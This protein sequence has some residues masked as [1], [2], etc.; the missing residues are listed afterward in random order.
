MEQLVGKPPSID[1][2]LAKQNGW[3]LSLDRKENYVV[4]AAINLWEKFVRTKGMTG[5][6]YY[7]A[8]F[9]RKF[10][11]NEHGIQVE[12]VVGWV[13][14]KGSKSATSHA[15]IEY[16]GKITDIS[17]GSTEGVF[18]TLPAEIIIH[19]FDYCPG[20]GTY[21]YYRK[22]PKRFLDIRYAATVD[23]ETSLNNRENDRLNTFFK[24]L[25]IN[26]EQEEDY[27]SVIPVEYQYELL[28]ALLK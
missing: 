17:L 28:A 7:L 3:L 19:G 20:I 13:V 14:Q 25:S 21:G 26:P 18:C 1:V 5:G 4:Q 8:L 16:Q 27:F 15:W 11:K 24:D 12:V 2:K 22:L 23:L 9:L 6:C 10:L